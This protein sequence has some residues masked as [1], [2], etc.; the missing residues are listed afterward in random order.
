MAEKGSLDQLADELK[1]LRDE[2][3]VQLKLA[4]KDAR[5]EWH[6]LE[7]KWDSFRARLEVVG[8]GGELRKGYEKI[9]RLL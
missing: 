6:A 4:S 1:Q 8:L 5:D 7:K 2:L 3:E 9:R